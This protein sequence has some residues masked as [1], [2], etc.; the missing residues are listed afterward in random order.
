MIYLDNAATTKPSRKADRDNNIAEKYK[1]FAMQELEH[2]T[3]VHDFAKKYIEKISTVIKAPE[4]MKEKWEN[5][6]E[7]YIE[8]TAMIKSLLSM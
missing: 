7:C 6:H 1:T 5:A 8:K 2:G 3:F 4:E